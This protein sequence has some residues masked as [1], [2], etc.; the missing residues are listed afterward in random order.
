M[1]TIYIVSKIKKL[2]KKLIASSSPPRG[3]HGNAKTA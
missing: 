1:Y 3:E 2:E